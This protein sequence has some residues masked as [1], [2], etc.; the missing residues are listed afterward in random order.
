MHTTFDAKIWKQFRGS[1]GIWYML[2]IGVTLKLLSHTLLK[3]FKV[4]F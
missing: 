4:I 1:S 2:G 3:V